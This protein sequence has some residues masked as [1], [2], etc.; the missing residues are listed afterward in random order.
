[1][2]V[3]IVNVTD[4]KGGAAKAAYRLHQGLLSIGLDSRMLVYQKR[5]QH[6]ST[7]EQVSGRWVRQ[8]VRAAMWR[9]RRQRKS[10]QATS[11][12]S[13]N[14]TDNWLTRQ[15]NALKPDIVHLHWV[16]DG[17][18]PIQSLKRITAPLVWTLHDMWAFTGGCHHS[19][20]CNRY[21]E[22]CG[23]CP[24]LNS[25]QLQD[26]SRRIWSMKQ[27]HW[28]NLNLNVI[29]P[30]NWL[31]NC[32]RASSLFKLYPVNVIPNGID[33]TVFKPVNTQMA[34]EVFN[35]PENKRLV[36]FGAI[37][38][39]S[40]PNKGFHHLVEALKRLARHKSDIE[41]LIFGANPP[42]DPPDWGLKVH[43]LGYLD[44][45]PSLV[46]AYNAADI[47]VAP[48]Q[49]ENLSNTV[50]E[51]LACGVPVVAFDIGGMPDMIQHPYN[52]YLAQPFS[53]ED[54]A[55]GIVWTLNNHDELSP[56]ARQTVLDKFEL[57]N[58]AHQYQAHYDLI[59]GR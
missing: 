12:W 10:L 16:G 45:L 46:L 51:A 48:S 33:T 24:V 30:S 41:V 4:T 39:T 19:C 20:G 25:N 42:A 28:D 54:L 35:L 40:D 57:T 50:M 43:Y 36:L 53:S 15:I 2:R 55:E 3:L 26:V 37:N 34:R 49:Q 17:Y 47:F 5:A 13:C 6:N 23:K 9:N 58:I 38:S 18:L 29:T 27:V 1:M 32:A 31:A 7:V 44:D 22:S 52:G 56:H 59:V 14:T 11:F 8:S 21:Q